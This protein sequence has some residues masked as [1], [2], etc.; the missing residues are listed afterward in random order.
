VLSLPEC[1]FT[2]VPELDSACTFDSCGENV[3]F[4]AVD[5]NMLLPIN[6]TGH[7]TFLWFCTILLSTGFNTYPVKYILNQISL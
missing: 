4:I 3:S 6:L 7:L 2:T 1:P 5:K